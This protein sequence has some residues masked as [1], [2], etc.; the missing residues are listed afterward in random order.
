MYGGKE[1]LIQN[2]TPL[3]Q[4]KANGEWFCGLQVGYPT[5]AFNEALLHVTVVKL[6]FF[7]IITGTLDLWTCK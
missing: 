6:L 7:K 5:P 1:V 3:L 4:L 2:N